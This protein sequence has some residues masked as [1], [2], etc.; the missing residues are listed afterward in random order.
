MNSWRIAA[1]IVLL[2]VCHVH[3]TLTTNTW[4]AATS[5]SWQSAI[6][7][8]AGMPSIADAIVSITN[9][10]SK[11]VLIDATTTNVPVSMTVSNL[12]VSAPAGTSNEVQLINSG[13]NVP[14]QVIGSLTIGH[15]GALTVSNGALTVEHS[16]QVPI[17]GTVTLDQGW[18]A[19][20]NAPYTA[21]G[22]LGQGRV[23][24]NGGVMNNS[25]LDLGELMGT[26]GTLTVAGGTCTVGGTFVIGANVGATGTVFVTGGQV[27]IGNAFMYVGYVGVGQM[28]LSNGAVRGTILSVADS[29]ASRGTFTMSGGT[30]NLAESLFI[31]SGASAAGAVWISGGLLTMTNDSTSVIGNQGVGQMTISNGTVLAAELD[32]AP[33]PGAAGT[34]TVAGGTLVLNQLMTTNNGAVIQFPAGIMTLNGAEIAN[35]REFDIG[36]AGQTAVLNLVGGT[37]YFASGLSLGPVINSTGTLWLTGGQLLVTNA[38]TEIGYEGVARMTVSNGTWQAFNVFVGYTAGSQ[39]TLTL[40]G[41]TNAFSF[42]VDIGPQS[43]ATGTLW[44]TGGQLTVGEIIVSEG[45]VGQMILSN[46]MCTAYG[47]SLGG[48]F[49]AQGTL[50]LAGGIITDLGDFAVGF[51]GTQTLWQA[52]GQLTVTNGVTEIGYYDLGRMTVSNGL[53]RA[54]NVIMGVVPG[55]QGTLTVAGGVSSIYSNITIG[56]TNCS[57]SGYAFITGGELHVTNDDATAVLEVRSGTL[58]QTGGILD[59]D[60]IVVTNPC[61]HFIHMGGTLIYGLETLTPEFDADGDGIPNGYEQANGLDPLNPADANA[62]NDGDG[63]SNLQEYL[64]GTDPNDSTS[65]F[66]ITTVAKEANNVRISWMTGLGKTNALQRTTGDGGSNYTTNTFATIFTVT[67]T[68]GTV[69][70]YLDIGGANIPAR[71]YRVR[72]VP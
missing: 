49:G 52:G 59:I 45:G 23:T 27:E 39:G 44:M 68:V 50:T 67:N 56:S 40:A 28:T 11:I 46:G 2:G 25:E 66:H 51:G 22:S 21:I 61:A 12:L 69:T 60:R 8:S 14:L 34:L 42:Y 70:N 13:T 48:A 17:D 38:S 71:Y 19:L 1:A 20:T 64:A 58:I 37:N 32:V 55:S 4:T 54:R 24:I 57:A 72:L 41:G 65:F 35:G 62:D 15:G 47:V 5:G 10:T 53:W 33:G 31:G 30:C 7:W 36:G 18:I 16:A 63:M 9:G 3:A 29:G 43:G 6:D 26:G